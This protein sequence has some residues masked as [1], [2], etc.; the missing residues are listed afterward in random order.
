LI[1][2]ASTFLAAAL[3]ACICGNASAQITPT[4]DTPVTPLQKQ[5]NRFD[6]AITGVGE[7]NTTVKGPIQRNAANSGQTVTQYASNTFGALGTLRYIARPYIGLE[8]NYGYARYTENYT[9]SPYQIQT[10][11]TEYTL[12]Y[13]VTPRRTLLGLKPF[14]AA[15]A[16]SIAF[17]PTPKGGQGAPEQARAV[18]YYHLGV[19]QDYLDGHFGLRAGFRQIF[20]LDP[21]FGQNY[22]TILKHASTYEPQVGFYLRY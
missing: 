4:G 15:G 1:R 6:L 11:A 2:K 14:V 19:Q 22:L 10:K 13:V 12:G 20:Y 3:F 16:G 7:F 5:L 21:D 8:L 9:T 17:K 18:Y